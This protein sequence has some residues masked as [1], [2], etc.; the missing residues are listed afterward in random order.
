M[1]RPEFQ[2]WYPTLEAGRWYPAD[3]L[4]DVVFEHLRHGSPQWRPQGRVPTDDHF[5]FRGG[6]PRQGSSR[7][8]RRADREPTR[9]DEELAPPTRPVSS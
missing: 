7:Q 8:T 2:D 3:E 6:T 5:V 4:T 9:P 1:L